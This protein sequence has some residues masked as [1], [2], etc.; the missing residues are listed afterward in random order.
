MP[1]LAFFVNVLVPDVWFSLAANT[2]HDLISVML[3]F[4]MLPVVALAVH[5]ILTSLVMVMLSL[6]FEVFL[7]IVMLAPWLFCLLPELTRAWS[8]VLALLLVLMLV[9]V[10]WCSSWAS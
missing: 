3:G 4:G 6:M 7:M 10:V 1:V 9:L 5:V 8:L 2:S